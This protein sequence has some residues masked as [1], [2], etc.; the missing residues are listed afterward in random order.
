M[1]ALSV[2]VNVKVTVVVPA[3]APVYLNSLDVASVVVLPW[4][5]VNISVGFVDISHFPAMLGELDAVNV[6]WLP[7]TMSP[8]GVAVIDVVLLSTVTVHVRPVELFT[9]LPVAK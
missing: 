7:L 6:A 2:G 1:F 8:G 3:F 5:I 9:L 4:S